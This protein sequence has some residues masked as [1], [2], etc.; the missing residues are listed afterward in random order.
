MSHIKSDIETVKKIFRSNIFT[1]LKTFSKAEVREFD[2]FVRSPFHNNRSELI[3]FWEEIR[4]KYPDFATDKATGETIFSNIYPGRKFRIDVLSRL[5]SNLL[6]LSEEYLAFKFYRKDEFNYNRN[7]LEQYYQRDLDKSYNKQFDKTCD[8][9][10]KGKLRNAEYYE[11][12][13][14]VEEINRFHLTKRD[15]TA[16][17][18]SVQKQ[19][20]SVW[21]YSVVTLLRLYTNAI[22]YVDQFNSKHDLGNLKLLLDIYEN[23]GFQKTPASEM[24][25]L[26][27]KLLRESR[28]DETF[29]KLKKLLSSSGEM[30][31]NTEKDMLY[32]AMLTYCWDM[33]VKQDKD[34]S[35]DEFQLII[36]ML[37]GGILTDGERMYSEW[38]MYAF[39]TATKA[40]EIEY[41]EGFIEKYKDMLPDKEKYNV[42]NHAYAELELVKK[43]FE[44]A[45][46]FLKLPNY[47]NVSEKIRAN[48]M[49][50]KIYYEL[51]MSEL[52][53]YNVD[54][55]RHLL[56]SEHSLSRNLRKIRSNY[57]KFINKLYKAKIG[58]TKIN[59]HELR[60]DINSTEVIFSKWLLEKIDEMEK[61]KIRR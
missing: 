26:S 1:V 39:L 13:M 49:Y 15:T 44:K 55:Y 59:L 11:R 27:L 37:D 21:Q 7:L 17:K 23:P 47:N 52:F 24:F 28:N 6:K 29:S 2:K 31:D 3:P 42:I 46:G 34:Y 30:L 10:N 22:Q 58:E 61:S 48:N 54:S 32:I 40:G 36:E 25:F 12:V 18:L 51:N 14:L 4:T 5:C 20:E 9:L 38:F 35:R 19:I 50:L 53:F 45:L 57:V 56:S 33:N 41:A 60:K 43:N 16:K 8:S